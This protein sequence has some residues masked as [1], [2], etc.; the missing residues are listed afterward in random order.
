MLTNEIKTDE[1]CQKNM[2]IYIANISAINNDF[3]NYCNNVIHACNTNAINDQFDKKKLKAYFIYLIEFP[4]KIFSKYKCIIKELLSCKF[5]ES[6]M[7]T[8]CNANDFECIEKYIGIAQDFSS[9]EQLEGK[10]NDL[11]QKIYKFCALFSCKKNKYVDDHDSNDMK[12]WKKQYMILK[13]IRNNEVH[14]IVDYVFSA[15]NDNV[16]VSCI[17]INAKD[18]INDVKLFI[19]D[20]KSF[21]Q[22]VHE[23]FNNLMEIIKQL[24]VI[25]T[26]NVFYENCYY[27]G[28]DNE[29]YNGQ[30]EIM[31]KYKKTRGTTISDE[32]NYIIEINK[33]INNDVLTV[34][35]ND[36]FYI[37]DPFFHNEFDLIG[38][39]HR[40]SDMNGKTL[41]E[42]KEYI[43]KMIS[44]QKKL[45]TCDN[46][47][48]TRLNSDGK[49]VLK[50]INDTN[51]L[52]DYIND[53]DEITK[54]IVR[55]NLFL[56]YKN[57]TYKFENKHI[58]FEDYMKFLCRYKYRL[59]KH[60]SLD[61]LLNLTD[62]NEHNKYTIFLDGCQKI[63]GQN[64]YLKYT[65][66]NYNIIEK[67]RVA[68]K[69][70]QTLTDIV[71]IID[72][73]ICDANYRCILYK[74]FFCGDN[75]EITQIQ[76]KHIF[77]L[78]QHNMINN[79]DIKK[80]LIKNMDELIPYI[81]INIDNN[82]GESHE[83]VD[84]LRECDINIDNKRISNLYFSNKNILP[85]RIS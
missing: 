84:I 57:L 62:A 21:V 12:R 27:I 69:L 46:I 52:P 51:C 19:E 67:Y 79:I 65:I 31:L 38:K 20:I 3:L 81:N 68:N 85:R 33:H 74:I 18:Q 10:R 56:V 13:N 6:D 24:I 4:Y 2:D 29:L 48:Y 34:K 15:N 16:S 42:C 66:K 41:D 44:E 53:D 36:N 14:S 82:E 43:R 83:V 7:H 22:H 73:G 50:F 8:F 70:Q 23:Q 1:Q 5:E 75:V 71:S 17:A 54:K 25:E 63:S 26:P 35:I 72:Q 28:A 78:K 9:K 59:E 11:M 37:T 49:Y 39:I 77:K 80:I 64:I 40:V 60:I 30:I 55:N 58:K 47:K 45:W 76:L 32:K 61:I